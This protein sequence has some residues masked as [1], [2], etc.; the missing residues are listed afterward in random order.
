MPT[1]VT[2]RS[3]QTHTHREAVFRICCE[4][5]D[6]AVAEIVR[7][8]QV[9]DKY[10]RSHADFLTSFAPVELHPGAPDVAQ[11]MARAAQRVGVGPMAAV[12]GT[13]AQLAVEA[14]L[15]AGA[16]EAIVDNGGDIYLRV[17]A[18]VTIGLHTGTAGLGDRLAFALAPDETPVAICSSSGT[19]GHSTSLGRCDLATVVASDAALA[20]AAATLAANLVK[21]I[22]DVDAA[23][24]RIAAIEGVQGVLIVKDDR[25]GLAGKLPS[26]V[27]AQR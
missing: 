1:A 20:D 10:I 15:R 13:M 17:T 7:Q 24:E 2:R 18:S 6:A 3:Y 14:A 25:V 8:R 9:L 22:D 11:H 26:L 27:H 4:K 12:A 19:M 16:E 5:F 21:S 23:L